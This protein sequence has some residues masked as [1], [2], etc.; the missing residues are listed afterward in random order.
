MIRVLFVSMLIMVSG[1]LP[2]QTSQPETPQSVPSAPAD[3]TRPAAGTN[4]LALQKASAPQAG[5]YTLS[6]YFSLGGIFMYPLLLLA[7]AGLALIS[8]RTLHALRHKSGGESFAEG[9]L[10]SVNGKNDP[11]VWCQ[12]HPALAMA[13]IFDKALARHEANGRSETVFV[14]EV[15]TLAAIDIAARERNLALIASIANLAPLVGFLGTVTGMI[16]AF[17]SIAQAD[18]VSARIVSSGIFEALITTAT[19][20]IIAIPASAFHNYAVHRIDRL[21]A[22]IEKTAAEIAPCLPKAEHLP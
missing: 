14:R 7:A 10:R 21:A 3:T 20:L 18:Q 2:A 8:E 17:G 6:H 15:E 1:S 9:L 22:T 5:G 4:A 19:G 11:R 12:R 16:G 13:Q